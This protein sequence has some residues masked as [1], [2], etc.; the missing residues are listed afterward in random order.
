LEDGT[1][2]NRQART[3]QA[4]RRVDDFLAHHAF[5]P[6]P[7]LL[8]KM[9]K[10]LSRSITRIM[11]MASRQFTPGNAVDGPRGVDRLRRR[12]RRDRMMPLVKIAKPLVK[13]AP[14]TAA[15]LRVPHA[16][17]DAV[18]VATAALSLAT[19]LE[20]HTKLI[21]SAGYDRTF[22]HDLRAD[23]RELREAVHFTDKARQQR[24]RATHV[25]ASELKKCTGTLMVIEGILMPRLANDAAL[26]AAWRSSRRVTARTGRPRAKKRRAGVGQ[27]QL[28]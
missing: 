25:I 12:I 21:I 14:G 22:L 3:L 13:F 9:H 23:A 1:M 17:A 11:D 7:P 24:S 10:E 15:A 27:P 26:A 18:T 28:S 6:Q 16:R 8:V 4:L 20:P 5:Q 19:A 2:D